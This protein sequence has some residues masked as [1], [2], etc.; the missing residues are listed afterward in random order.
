MSSKIH[1][2]PQDIEAAF[3][4]ALEAADLEAMM[5]VWSEDEEII[6]VHPGGPRLVGYRAVRESWRQIFS[7][8]ERLNLRVIPQGTVTTPFAIISHVLELVGQQSDEQRYAPIAATNVYVRGPLGWR[9]V[10]HHAS[11]L[12]PGSLADTPKVLH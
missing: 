5:A 2:S 1:S 3:Y 12:P 4:A 8:G 6:C 9:M 7:S 11:V 10:A